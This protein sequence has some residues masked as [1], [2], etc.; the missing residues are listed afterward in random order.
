MKYRCALE[1]LE[2]FDGFPTAG[3]DCTLPGVRS[4]EQTQTQ[5]L[6]LSL[7]PKSTCGRNTKMKLEYA[8]RRTNIKHVA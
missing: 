6:R 8:I 3:S 1:V 7:L 2:V 4:A 5:C